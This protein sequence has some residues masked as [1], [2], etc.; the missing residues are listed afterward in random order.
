METGAG[1][2]DFAILGDVVVVAGGLEAT[3]LVAG[4]EGFDGECTVGSG[5]GA[6]DD[7]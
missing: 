3:R 6:V 7:D 1:F 4:F 5:G 2:V